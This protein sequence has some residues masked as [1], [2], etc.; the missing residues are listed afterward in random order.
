MN[1]E[2]KKKYWLRKILTESE[3]DGIIKRVEKEI[4]KRER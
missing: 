2:E 1:R 3:K 4:K